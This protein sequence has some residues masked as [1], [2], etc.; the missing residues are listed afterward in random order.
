[1]RACCVCVH[2]ILFCPHNHALQY[3]GKNNK[4]RT[5][6]SPGGRDRRFCC[7]LI[8]FHTLHA[9]GSFRLSRQAFLGEAIHQKPWRQ[10]P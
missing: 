7:S 8:R 4:K 6:Q 10:S 5:S 2:I 9:G 3:N 1:M